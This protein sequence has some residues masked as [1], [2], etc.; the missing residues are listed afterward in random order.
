MKVLVL[1]NV[2]EVSFV[3]LS[4]VTP[5]VGFPGESDLLFRDRTRRTFN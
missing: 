3:T 4:L 2:P 5:Y 1:V